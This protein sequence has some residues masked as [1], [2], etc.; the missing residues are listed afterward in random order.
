MT[1]LYFSERELGKRLL[2]NEEID[3]KVYN[4]IVTI[5]KRYIDNFCGEFALYCEDD[6]AVICGTNVNLL[7]ASIKAEIGIEEPLKLL[8]EWEDVNTYLTLDF[9][10]FCYE[11]LSDI[12]VIRYHSYQGHNDLRLKDTNT[13]KEKFRN[14]IN[15]LFERNGLIFEMDENGKV[16]RKLPLAMENILTNINLKTPDTQLNQLLQLAIDN[17]KKP[18]I[19]DRKIAL[20][21]L[22]D[23]FERMK[24]YYLNIKKDK[25]KSTEELLAIVAQDTPG[26]FEILDSEFKALT[27]IGNNFQI[28]HFE[29]DKK[30]IKSSKHIDYLFYR[31][32]SA[33]NLCVLELS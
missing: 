5:V 8:E 31:M 1:E 14:K 6:S 2:S 17:I 20:E 7:N 11:N 19:N 29:K 33:I 25:K 12:E 4:G 22:W 18:N 3:Y 28:R 13:I 9:L 30:E 16:I 27:F 10:E 21:K 15:R 26:F 24:T 23:A 32:I